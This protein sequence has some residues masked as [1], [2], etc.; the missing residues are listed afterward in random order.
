[1]KKKKLLLTSNGFNFICSRICLKKLN[2]KKKIIL[3][4]NIPSAVSSCVDQI[5]VYL[6][7]SSKVDHYLIVHLIQHLIELDF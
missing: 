1:M 6:Y 2:V 4:I 5:C 3:L 7:Y